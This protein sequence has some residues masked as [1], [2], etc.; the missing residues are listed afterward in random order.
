MSVCNICVSTC[1]V[2]ACIWRSEV[3]VC[4]C[5]I[6]VSTCLCVCLCMEAKRPR[7]VSSVA[8]NLTFWNS[9]FG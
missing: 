9:P 6:C 7:S 2:C 4:V 3:Y 1:F 5:N 8:F